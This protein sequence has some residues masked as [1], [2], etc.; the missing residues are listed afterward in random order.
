MNWELAKAWDDELRKANA[1]GPSTIDGIKKVADVDELLGLLAP[2]QLCNK[3]YVRIHS[4]NKEHAA[5]WRRKSEV[6][7]VAFLNHLGF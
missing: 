6:E 2:F 4:G 5:G 3:D 1:K 7:L